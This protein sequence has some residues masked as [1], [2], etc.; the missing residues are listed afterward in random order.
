MQRSVFRGCLIVL[1]LVSSS[2]RSGA[3]P[4]AEPEAEPESTPAR[5]IDRDTTA[6]VQT[7]ALVYELTQPQEA[8]FAAEIPFEFTNDTGRTIS[9]VNCS[10]GLATSLEKNVNGTWVQFYDPA[11]LMCLSPPIHIPSGETFEGTAKIYGALPGQNASPEFGSADLDGEYR[12]VWGN[13][14]Q[15]YDED[16]PGFGKPLD[17]LRSNPFA[18][19][20]PR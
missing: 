2:C 4:P 8:W 19:V 3:V 6:P 11:L 12:L 5:T 7:K 17:P 15:D 20:D 16:A 13:L 14:V 18:L 9:I 10:G 1:A